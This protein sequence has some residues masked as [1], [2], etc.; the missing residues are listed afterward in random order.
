LFQQRRTAAKRGT[1][2]QLQRDDFEAGEELEV[3]HV[4]GGHIEAKMERRGSDHQVF[5]GDGDPLSGLFA[6][7][8]PGKLRDLQ[9][10]PDAR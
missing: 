3:L 6:L 8:L 5:E 1:F 7:D 10:D 4:E 2:D 9:R